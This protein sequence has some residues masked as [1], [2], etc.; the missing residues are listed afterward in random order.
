MNNYQMNKHGVE[1]RWYLWKKGRTKQAQN[2]WCEAG[3]KVGKY[4][5]NLSISQHNAKHIVNAQY[6]W[7]V[8]KTRVKRATGERSWMLNQKS[9]GGTS[10]LV[11]WL[12]LDAPNAEG[13]GSIPGQGT[14]ISHAKTIKI[15]KK[16]K[17]YGQQGP[18]VWHR[19]PCSMSWDKPQWKRI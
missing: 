16:K 5:F 8:A 7:S 13:T 15:K 18:T 10:L 6:E 12:K 2:S 9:Y 4:E 11:R 1:E 19:E 3:E 17:S 14:K